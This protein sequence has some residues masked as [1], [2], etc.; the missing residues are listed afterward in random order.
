MQKP[1]IATAVAAIVLTAVLATAPAPS[2]EPG[3]AGPPLVTAA[4]TMPAP[5]SWPKRQGMP[6]LRKVDYAQCIESCD[7]YYNDCIRRGNT[8][9][10]CD[11]QHNQC[12][13]GCLR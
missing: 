1:A 11:G 4:V 9:A 3:H 10:Y 13:R 12:T 5:N 8:N 2:D 6:G 7:R